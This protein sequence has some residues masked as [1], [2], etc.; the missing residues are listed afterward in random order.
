MQL[1]PRKSC[2]PLLSTWAFT[3]SLSAAPFQ[4]HNH[5]KSIDFWCMALR[6]LAIILELLF[7]ITIILNQF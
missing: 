2:K 5:I 4:M 7:N 3:S 1:R 6:L